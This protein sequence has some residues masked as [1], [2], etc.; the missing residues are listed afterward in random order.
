MCHD[1]HACEMASNQLYF[2]LSVVRASSR[3]CVCVYVPLSFYS[4]ISDHI[5][6]KS[7]IRILFPIDISFWAVS[8]SIPSDTILLLISIVVDLR[9]QLRNTSMIHDDDDL[10]MIIELYHLQAKLL[11]SF[12]DEILFHRHRVS[13]LNEKKTHIADEVAPIGTL[14]EF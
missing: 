11:F 14:K 3:V 9:F 6:N 5:Q 8:V 13:K 12:L 1:C 4:F 7:Y 10:Q 2:L